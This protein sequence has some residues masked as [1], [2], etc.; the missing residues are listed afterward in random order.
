MAKRPFMLIVGERIQL[1]TGFVRQRGEGDKGA[2]G[3]S[4]FADF[5][6]DLVNKELLITIKI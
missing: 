4:E 5:V 6:N 2:M 3:V 1:R